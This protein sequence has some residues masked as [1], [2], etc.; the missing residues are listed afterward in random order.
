M[1]QF[2]VIAWR[3]TEDC[4]YMFLKVVPCKD[5]ET[6]VKVKDAFKE[7]YL[8]ENPVRGKD[9]EVCDETDRFTCSHVYDIDDFSVSVREMDVVED[10]SE[11]LF[12]ETDLFC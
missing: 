4:V 11:V 3:R 1:K 5:F 7:K 9:V 10:V 2:T 8:S 12:D 6:A